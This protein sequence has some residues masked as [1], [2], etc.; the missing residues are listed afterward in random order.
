MGATL[1]V[2]SIAYLP[3]NFFCWI[4]PIVSL[5]FGLFCFI[6]YLRHKCIIHDK[7]K[8]IIAKDLDLCRWS[9]T[10]DN[11][12]L[13]D[14]RRRPV[15]VNQAH[16]CLEIGNQLYFMFLVTKKTLDKNG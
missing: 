6:F 2:P 1:G 4:S 5:L 3:F 14:K 7:L 8:I 10:I 11:P 13:A 15:H 9:L 12:D 16:G